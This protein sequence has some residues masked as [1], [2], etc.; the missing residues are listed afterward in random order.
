VLL[1]RLYWMRLTRKGRAGSIVKG[2]K[3]RKG[4]IRPI[5][6]RWSS[7]RR[8]SERE[9][10][11][12]PS[13]CKL[14]TLFSSTPSIS[15]LIHSFSVHVYRPRS[16][17]FPSMVVSLFCPLLKVFFRVRI[18]LPTPI[19]F[20]IDFQNS[21]QLSCSQGSKLSASKKLS[22]IA[23]AIGLKPRKTVTPVQEPATPILPLH[24]GDIETPPRPTKPAVK[25]VPVAVGWSDPRALQP[26]E[27][28]DAY[29][30][31]VFSTDLDPFAT[32]AKY[33]DGIPSVSDSLRFS[34]FSEV[35][36]LDPHLHQD[37]PHTHNRISFA[38]SSS[39]SHHR[40]DITSDFSPISSPLLS[41]VMSGHHLSR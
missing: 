32:A 12:P 5:R 30:Q 2:K 26:E 13:E 6:E 38:S 17:L 19:S 14:S 33:S 25:P 37:A 23:T 39:L 4:M 8:W 31:S 20:L 28:L 18:L 40:S 35:S 16:L 24:T 9:A 34:T 22:T 15:S 27:F 10:G 21:K 36:V 29:P 11:W 41:P 7:N 3:E 1:R